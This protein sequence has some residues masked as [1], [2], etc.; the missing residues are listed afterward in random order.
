MWDVRGRVDFEH[1]LGR[2]C[3]LA[4]GRGVSGNP[5]IA[6]AVGIMRCRIGLGVHPSSHLRSSCAVKRSW[7]AT[8]PAFA[9]SR[10]L[11]PGRV[12]DYSGTML[13]VG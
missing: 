6:I 5:L 11:L 2:G 13:V 3:V 7:E 1:E 9:S 8:A 4:N 12:E 10:L